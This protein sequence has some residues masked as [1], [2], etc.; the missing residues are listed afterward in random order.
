MAVVILFFILIIA[1][2]LF[3]GMTVLLLFVKVFEKSVRERGGAAPVVAVGLIAG[4]AAGIAY[5]WMTAHLVMNDLV[6]VGM[7]WILLLAPI[8]LGIILKLV[9]P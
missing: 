8:G 6:S 9:L 3:V 5:S 1:D 4:L 7:G 2:G